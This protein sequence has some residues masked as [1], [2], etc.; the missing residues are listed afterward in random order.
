[1]PRRRLGIVLLVPPPFDREIDGLRRGLGD[2]SLGRIPAHL[3]LVPPVNV[4][5]DRMAE[6]LAV[7]RG[8]AVAT[9]PFE[10]RL[11]PPTTFLPDN[12]VLYLAVTRGGDEVR[13]L[14]DRTFL[15]PLA[16]ELTWPF[17]PHVTLADEAEEEAILDALATLSS[18]LVDVTFSR[19]HV[20]EEQPGRVWVPIA[21]AP[22]AAP[23]VVGR[24]GLELELSV[25]EQLDDEGARFAA[26]EWGAYDTARYGERLAHVD[27]LAVTARRRGRIVGIAAGSASGSSA[28]L[29]DLLVAGPARGEGVGSHL[30]AAFCSE[31]AARGADEVSVRTEQGG[32]AEAFYASRGWKT[33]AV[34]PR[35]RHDRDFV[36][37]VRRT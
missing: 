37:M 12:P 13:A 32:P 14:R 23:A 6:A 36:H 25:A 21:D 30:L 16:R 15:D 26:E 17:V 34:L 33:V 4:H 27:P 8:A 2:R 29:R 5:E 24:G 3:T 9:R 22:F 11:G 19:I 7:V 31:A 18:Y 1:M 10:V 20:L 35:Y 28:H